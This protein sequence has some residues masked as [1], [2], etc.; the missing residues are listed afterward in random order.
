MITSRTTGL[1]TEADRSDHRTLEHFVAPPCQCGCPVG[2]DVPSYLAYTWQGD[3]AK[4]YEAIS[5]TNPL[6][7]I[8]GRVCDA[9]CERSCRRGDSDGPVAIRNIKRFVLEQIASQGSEQSS[10]P[11][12]AVSQSQLVAIVGGG[13][14]GLSAAQDLAE[15][16][17][18]VDIF[19]ASDRLGGMAV[20]GIPR[21]RLPQ[22][23]IAQDIQ[24]LL[25]HCPGIQV[26]YHQRLGDNLHLE[27]LKQDYPAV[28]LAIGANVGSSLSLEAEEPSE[29][30]VTDGLSF[31]R[32]VNSGERPQLPKQVVVIGGGDVAMDA[33]RAAKRMPGVEQVKVLYRRGI[34]QMPAREEERAGALAEG[35]EIVSHT[36]PVGITAAGVRCVTTQAAGRDQRVSTIAGSEH[37]VEAGMVIMAVGQRSECAELTES[38]L[39]SEG[40]VQADQQSTATA[41]AGVFAAGDATSGGASIVEA[42]SQGH[43]AAY[44]IKAHLRGD[45][46]T[47]VYATPIY[48]RQVPLAQDP[49]WERSG[50]QATPENAFSSATDGSSEIEQSYSEAQAKA[51]ASRCF[52]CDAETGS[53]DF[54]VASRESIFVMARTEPDNAAQQEQ[55]LASRLA[56]APAAAEHP[57]TGHFDELVFLPANLTRLVI[58]PYRE[59]CDLSVQLGGQTFATP[60]VVCGFDD[61]P[62]A[63][64]TA[65]ASGL[66]QAGGAYL[67]RSPLEGVDWLQL[68]DEHSQTEVV[69]AD[70]QAKLVVLSAS[71]LSA[72]LPNY[73][74][75]QGLA[76]IASS[77]NLEL[78][79]AKALELEIGCVLLDGSGELT[80]LKGAPDLNLLRRAVAYL[81]AQ[82][83]EEAID[84]LWFGGARNGTD[85][86]K[87]L[88]LGAS[89]VA[90]HAAF[91]FGLGASFDGQ[92]LSFSSDMGVD[93]LTER[94]RDL[95]VAFAAE[96]AMMAKCTGKTRVC[97]LEPEDL[98]ALSVAT[99]Q[100]VG[101]SLPG[102]AL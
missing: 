8:C 60:T 23:V 30:S 11:P 2:T 28:L 12:V 70:P 47:P 79:L 93:E 95:L 96:A 29:V 41:Q 7:S 21:F 16:G 46:V 27:Q 58:D 37:V 13:P 59:D 4:A 88:S 15:A 69:T 20:W 55:L 102:A 49:E 19:E 22:G 65:L 56:V 87:S 44:Y 3:Y 90:M 74:T 98:R 50:R 77:D 62:E 34:E 86:A 89:A 82:N 42:M 53:S 52:R 18:A 91:C 5:A 78:V 9:P 94:S 32:Q 54:N 1:V 48:T 17:F 6:P 61:A 35:I 81:R 67:G 26:H 14:A 83:A 25:A 36:Q 31:L 80:E 75:W 72:P 76:V 39:L 73:A 99:A 64:R 92:T 45:I 43:R 40:R 84:L 68:C 101:I 24:R 33:C 66:S 100:A 38:G 51:E 97:N 63:I 71:Q 10:L 85:V 57:E